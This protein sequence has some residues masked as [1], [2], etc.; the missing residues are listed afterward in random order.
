MASSLS[1]PSPSQ[2]GAPETVTAIAEACLT[3][4]PCPVGLRGYPLGKRISGQASPALPVW[5]DVP[6]QACLLTRTG[7]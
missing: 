2:M 5:A 3:P 7:I 6:A 1:T 4:R